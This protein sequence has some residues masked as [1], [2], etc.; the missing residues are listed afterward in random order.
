MDQVKIGALIAKLRKAKGLTQAQLGDMIGV[1]NRAV[2]KW[3]TGQTMPDIGNINELSKILGI[4]TD[5]LFKGKLNDDTIINKRLSKNNK[6]FL[7]LIPILLLILAIIFII[8][9]YNNKP[10]I[11][12][13]Y[14][15]NENEYYV[16]GKVIFNKKE[17][18]IIINKIF[19]IDKNTSD[20]TIHDYEY[21]FLCNEVSL[22]GYGYGGF[23][24]Q[25]YEHVNKIN[26][27]LEIFSIDINS[28]YTVSK[29]TI[30]ENGLQL[31]LPF[32]NEEGNVIR[33]IIEL[34][35]IK[36]KS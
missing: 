11:Y 21:E 3:E 5:E 29:K 23:D 35:L 26:D 32:I 9:K 8:I 34:N 30:I 4:T 2:S 13:L 22:Y 27:F 24:N 15:A 1:G 25:A 17:T 7:I 16:E 20:K 33:L 14:A 10:E 6:H 19:I 12:N 36:A 18:N 31:T 28:K